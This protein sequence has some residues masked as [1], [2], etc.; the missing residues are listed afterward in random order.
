ME[1]TEIRL[2]DGRRISSG[3]GTSIAIREVKLTECVNS[4]EELTLGSVCAAMVEITVLDPAGELLLAAGQELI[5]SKTND[6]GTSYPVG[7]F[8]A[9]KPVRASANCVKITAYDRVSKLDKDLSEWLASLD[10]WPYSLLEFGKMAC[11]TCGVTLVTDAFPHGDLSVQAFSGQG[12][13]GRQILQW[14]AEIAG[15]FCRATPEGMLEMAWYTPRELLLTPTGEQY[16]YFGGISL[17]EYRVAPVEKVQVRLT[18]NDVGGIYPPNLPE[19]NTYIISGNYLLTTEDTE[20]LHAVAQSTYDLLYGISY[21]PGKLVVPSGLCRAGDIVSVQDRLGTV[22]T[23]YVMSRVQTGQTDTLECTG[24][25]RRDSSTAVNEAKYAALSGKV[26]ELQMGVE[27]L[28]L[29]NKDAAG[30][31]AS[32]ELNVEGINTTVSGQ[33]EATESLKQAVTEVKQSSQGVAVSVQKICDDGVSRVQTQ[34][35]YTFDDEG[36]KIQKSGEEMENKLDNTGMYVKQN[37]QVILQANNRGV[38]A[39]DITVR[40]Y[41]V[42]GQNSRL[43]DYGSRTGCFWIGG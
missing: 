36:M 40:N 35:G 28:T 19:G 10:G 12:I 6:D 24:S 39:A 43:E 5:I 42:V 27:G 11:E 41:L 7:V 29:Q 13:T 21:T 25:P 15:R 23:V 4:R 34:T 37:G 14:V 26:L 17:A 2:P 22:H 38:E 20:T 31:L 18:D 32:L 9:E 1:K 30:R 8:I 33:L 3:S 16:F